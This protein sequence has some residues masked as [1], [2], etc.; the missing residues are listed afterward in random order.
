MSDHPS[1]ITRFS[2]SSFYDEKCVL[3]GGTDGSG[4]H[5]LLLP[6]PEGRKHHA[7]HQRKWRNM[8]VAPFI[9][10]WCADCEGNNTK[11]GLDQ[12][13]PGKFT[14]EEIARITPPEQKPAKVG[15]LKKVKTSKGE[16]SGSEED[17]RY[18]LKLI[19]RD[20]IEE[21]AGPQHISPSGNTHEDFVKDLTTLINCYS[22]DAKLNLPD[23]V[24]AEYVSDMFSGLARMEKEMRGWTS[25]Y[26]VSSD[27]N[28]GTVPFPTAP[29]APE[30]IKKLVP[31][32]P[33][34]PFGT[35]DAGKLSR[36]LPDAGWR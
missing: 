20:V 28:G 32:Y 12:P 4:D 2:D 3:C 27:G 33:T 31:R 5:S 9:F 35:D 26:Y 36:T 8:S 14:A 21:M 29:S 7:S 13:C 15:R 34:D 18:I 17:L 30:P 19:E 1:H 6:C 23:N 11:G 24:L 25:I 22:L 16:F 10:V